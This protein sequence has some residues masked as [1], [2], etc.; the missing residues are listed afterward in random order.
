MVLSRTGYMFFA[1]FAQS[2]E[3]NGVAI[4]TSGKIFPG[5]FHD[6]VDVLHFQINYFLAFLADKM[7]VGGCSGVKA[8][9][10][11]RCGD[12][13]DFPQADQQRQIP[14]Y[15][16]QADIGVNPARA[17]VNHIGGGVI[18][19]GL[20]QFFD[21][22]SLAA[23]FDGHHCAL[24]S[25]IRFDAVRQQLIIITVTEISIKLF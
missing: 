8:V 7:V 17:L 2:E 15:G 21:G 6:M 16:P 14:V 9:C 11:F 25:R 1:F 19:P 22:L 3:M 24:L 23:V 12:L 10:A 4:N 18:R 5:F 20:Q 13:D